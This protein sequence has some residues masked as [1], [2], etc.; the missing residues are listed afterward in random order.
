MAGDTIFK[1]KFIMGK[2]RSE[3]EKLKQI[4][5]RCGYQSFWLKIKDI[6]WSHQFP[7]QQSVYWRNFPL[8][9]QQLMTFG[10]GRVVEKSQT[11][12]ARS[13]NSL[14]ASSKKRLRE[15]PA[16][17]KKDGSAAG[18]SKKQRMEVGAA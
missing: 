10:N 4:C 7:G 6:E 9:H 12:P 14:A 15:D 17:N 8:T 16:G 11:G 5:R 2:P 1:N 3:N 18:P 13:N